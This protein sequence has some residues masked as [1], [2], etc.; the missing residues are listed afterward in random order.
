[1]TI[2][3]QLNGEPRMVAVGMSIAAALNSAALPRLEA[4]E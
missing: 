2:T 3:I 1:M 4:A